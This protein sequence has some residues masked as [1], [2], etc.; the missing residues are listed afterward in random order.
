M[1][2]AKRFRVGGNEVKFLD[3]VGIRQSVKHRPGK[4]LSIS[5]NQRSLPALFANALPRRVVAGFLA[6]LSLFL[7]A[8][9]DAMSAACTQLTSD[10]NGGITRNA[11]DPNVFQPYYTGFGSGEEVYYTITSTG[12]AAFEKNANPADSGSSVAGIASNTVTVL[13]LRPYGGHEI[14]QSGIVTLDPA[15]TYYFF[16]Q[17]S[18]N[19][20]ATGSVT[21]TAGCRVVSAQAPVAGAVST[22]VTA[23]STANAVT[24][25]LSGGTA[26]SVTVATAPS[27]GTATASGTGITYTPTAGYSGSDSFT[28]TATNA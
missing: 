19:A 23:N 15:E 1:F 4:G 6:L 13:D 12:T 14:N 27:H 7:G 9:A 26:T 25:A 21:M 20:G 28:Y 8:P 18:T 2:D 16:V 24:L 22:T 11:G 3:V 17:G 10:F 5:D